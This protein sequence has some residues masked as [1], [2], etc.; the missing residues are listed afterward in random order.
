LQ[1]IWFRTHLTELFHC[2][3]INSKSQQLLHEEESNDAEQ[4]C[5][6]QQQCAAKEAAAEAEATDTLLPERS[7]RITELALQVCVYVCTLS[8]YADTNL[9]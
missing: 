7:R 1:I 6:D 2:T 4:V 5:T 8:L 9:Q 3:C